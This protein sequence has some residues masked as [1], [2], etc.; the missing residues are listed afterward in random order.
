M[1]EAG[2]ARAKRH[3]IKSKYAGDEPRN[4]ELTIHLPK[5]KR[6]PKKKPKRQF[7]VSANKRTRRFRRKE[8]LNK[9]ADWA[10]YET[11]LNATWPIVRQAEKGE[12]AR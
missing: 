9:R 12:K 7:S 6:L 3:G 8:N 1:T 11:R 10:A 4:D 5:I 2:K